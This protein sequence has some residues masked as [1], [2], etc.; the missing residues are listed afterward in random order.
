MSWLRRRNAR[1]GRE[2]EALPA[3]AA[4]GGAS[5]GDIY[6]RVAALPLTERNPIV[7]IPGIM[8]SKLVDA[9]CA[10]SVWG[11]FSRAYADP[12]RGSNRR[13]ISLPMALGEPLDR[14]ASPGAVDGAVAR[15]RPR[16]L[17]FDITAYGD[18][19]Q[20][21]GIQSGLPSARHRP[22]YGHE[23]AFASFEFGYDWRRS[24]DETAAELEAFLRMA[25]YFVQ[26]VR[27]NSEPVSFDVVAHS[28]GG[29]VL[30]YYLRYGDQ[31]LPLDGTLP[32]IT[33][34]GSER[35]TRALIIGTPNAGS[36]AAIERLV[37]GL[38]GIPLV[39]PGYDPF[40]VGTMPALYQLLPRNRHRPFV[41]AGPSSKPVDL[42]DPAF[43]IARGWGLADPTGDERLAL[44]LD[45]VDS[46]A[47]RH[48]TAL[49]HLSKCLRQAE[50]LHRALDTPAEP[51]SPLE[52][53]LVAG[54]SIRTVAAYGGRIG[55]RRLRVARYGA[56]DGTVLRSS[57]LLDERESGTWQ[58]GVASPIAWASVVFAAADH[59]ALTRDR[60]VLDNVLFRLL[61]APRADRG[62]C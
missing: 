29:L 2:G 30:R 36:A 16:R 5:I 11:D 15:A 31:R 41:D 34:A 6:A 8:G 60:V 50:S 1:R 35:V 19:L 51:P 7:F 28:M 14:L 42:Y 57:A 21:V 52:L 43:W 45:G 37:T 23:G 26:A 59:M 20:T 55:D 40:I 56:G 3:R 25:S 12:G 9:D 27:G 39:H 10:R 33:W 48:E 47:A 54:D 13:L 22:E 49:D 46:K 53:H 24:L 38:P 4:A 32:R 44:Q 18:I 17:P 62:L 61:D 58:P